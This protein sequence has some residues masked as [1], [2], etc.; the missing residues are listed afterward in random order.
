MIR[1]CLKD[2][3]LRSLRDEGADIDYVLYRRRRRE[4]FA[5]FDPETALD[6]LATELGNR[7][8]RAEVR[9]N[10]AAR[11]V[12]PGT[13]VAVIVHPDPVTGEAWFHLLTG[14]R[15]ARCTQTPV[16]AEALTTVLREEEGA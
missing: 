15:V 1:T 8:I 3:P 4:R 11:L 14:E 16:A 13:S 10:Y 7:G 5:C 2:S 12:V 9:G 6:A